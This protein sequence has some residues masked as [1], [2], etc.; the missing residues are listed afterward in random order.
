MPSYLG[1][2]PT[3]CTCDKKPCA[4]SMGMSLSS[5]LTSTPSATSSRTIAATPAACSPS[6]AEAWLDTSPSR[7]GGGRQS[8][9]HTGAPCCRT[10][11]IHGHSASALQRRSHSWSWRRSGLRSRACS[12]KVR[13]RGGQ[14]RHLGPRRHADVASAGLLTAMPV[15]RRPCAGARGGT[16]GSCKAATSSQ[17][18]S[19]PVRTSGSGGR[20]AQA[21]RMA[22]RIGAATGVGGGGG[23]APAAWR[24]GAA[25]GEA[26][27]ARAGCRVSGTGAGAIAGPTARSASSGARSAAVGAA[28]HSTLP[29]FGGGCAASPPPPARF[30]P[31]PPRLRPPLPL[32]P[33]PAA[34]PPAAARR[35]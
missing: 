2:A 34:A 27:R 13:K 9:V 12:A 5:N 35:Q 7:S 11:W 32:A 3:G 30:L 23:A 26:S 17:E 28:F 31:R 29:P 33:P 22:A 1:T 19:G 14:V 25:R 10:Y 4:R 16:D 6:S 8:S 20:A 18:V 15:W 24:P 21:A